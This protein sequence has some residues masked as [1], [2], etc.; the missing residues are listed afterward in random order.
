MSEVPS[1]RGT[2][3]GHG[4]WVTALATTPQYPDMLVS[5]SRDKTILVWK[6]TREAQYGYAK[7]S[8]HGHNHF[9]SDIAISAEGSYCISSSWDKTLRLWDL[10]T[11]E[12][13]RRF[14]G[15]DADVL[16]V[17]FSPSNKVIL[18]ASRDKSIKLWNTIGECKDTIKDA[19]TEWVSSVR[20]SPNMKNEAFVTSGWDKLLKVSY[21]IRLSSDSCYFGVG[22][23]YF[24]R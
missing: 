20:C 15:H 24:L 22:N 21:L 19:H 16:S 2:L 18:S 3:E 23:P 9:V 6:L 7:K 11:G 8:L 4:N 17:T 14:V 13:R 5:A 12:T 10:E 1:Y